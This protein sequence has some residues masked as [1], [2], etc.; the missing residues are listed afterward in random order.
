[1]LRSIFFCGPCII[2]NHSSPTTKTYR[3]NLVTHISNDISLIA[4]SR[5]SSSCRSINIFFVLNI[6]HIFNNNST[7]KL[8]RATAIAAFLATAQAF[9]ISNGPRYVEIG[10][11]P[12]TSF[13]ITLDNA[14][15]SRDIV[16]LSS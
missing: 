4:L 6:T 8:S 11:T 10:M 12:I 14:R 5:E 3:R 7:M 2:I 13:F 9:T 16:C 1:L 15:K